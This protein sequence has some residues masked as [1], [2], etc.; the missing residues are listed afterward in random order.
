MTENNGYKHLARKPG[1]YQQLHVKGRNIRADVLY[2]YSLG[3]DARTAEELARDY[4]L[5]L[6]VVQEAIDYCIHNPD[7]LK[8]DR[9]RE[10]E[11]ARE[12]ESRHPQI[13][14]PGYVPES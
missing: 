2:E 10:F 8:S 9:D 5:P 1:F 6:E 3:E 7:V 12:F 13:V 4:D 11:S 14:P